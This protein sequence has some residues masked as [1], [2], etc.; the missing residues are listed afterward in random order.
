[1]ALGASYDSN[2]NILLKHELY[3]TKRQLADAQNSLQFLKREKLRVEHEKNLLEIQVRQSED[4]EMK[5][6]QEERDK[7]EELKEVHRQWQMEKD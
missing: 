2:K 3:Q 1:M 7:E 6:R 4:H 5:R